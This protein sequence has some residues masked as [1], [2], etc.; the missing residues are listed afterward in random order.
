MGKYPGAKTPLYYAAL[1]G[2]LNP[3]EQLIVGH[4]QHVDTVYGYCRAPAVAALAGR[5]F[6]VAQPLDRNGAS[7]DIRGEMKNTSLHSAVNYGDLEMIQVLLVCE[8]DV[9]ALNVFGVCIGWR[10]SQ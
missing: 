7:L 10:S 5:H 4:P 6:Q 3:V 2:F 1:C 8:V 9:D